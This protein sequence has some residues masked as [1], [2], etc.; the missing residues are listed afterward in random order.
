MNN[1]ISNILIPKS[2]EEIIRDLHKLNKREL[3]IH[4]HTSAERGYFN[5]VKILISAGA[6]INYKDDYSW[7]VLTVAVYR[8]NKHIVQYLIE[9][10]ANINAKRSD[11]ETPLILATR[12]HL[13]DMVDL[14]LKCGANMNIK[15]NSGFSALY[16][17][18]VDSRLSGVFQKYK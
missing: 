10:G 1:G 17:V 16:Y 13:V 14:L 12:Y 3:S 7:P 6:N 8:S 9:N 11:G 15:D 2:E 5:L 18:D 4:L